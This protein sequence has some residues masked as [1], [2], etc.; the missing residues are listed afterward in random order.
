MRHWLWADV[1]VTLLAGLCVEFPLWI[2]GALLPARFTTEVRWWMSDQ[3]T[4]VPTSL[5][6]LY[7]RYVEWQGLRVVEVDHRPSA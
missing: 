7:R 4:R 2:A 6:P 5:V 1:V 3:S